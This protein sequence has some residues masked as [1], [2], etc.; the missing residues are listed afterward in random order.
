M[1]RQARQKSESGLEWGHDLLPLSGFDH[2]A[3]QR[4]IDRAGRCLET[5]YNQLTVDG[6]HLLF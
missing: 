1:G 5:G 6:G 2:R 4:L 3:Y